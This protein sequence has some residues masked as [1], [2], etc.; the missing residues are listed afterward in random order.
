MTTIKLEFESN[1]ETVRKTAILT[2]DL[3]DLSK[4]KRNQATD[5]T[6]YPEDRF[7]SI[8]FD[9][10]EELQYEVEFEYEDYRK[11]LNPIKAITWLNGVIDDSQYVEV[12]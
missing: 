10:S 11:T 6:E 5:I 1:G 9:E 8:I 3:S 2:D 4:S 12:I 7:W